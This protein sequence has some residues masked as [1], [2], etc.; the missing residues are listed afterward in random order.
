MTKP[1]NEIANI[2]FKKFG[3]LFQAIE[4]DALS[5]NT[6]LLDFLAT[7]GE[8]LE[9]LRRLIMLQSDRDNLKQDFT[10]S[11]LA[12]FLA[13][14]SVTGKETKI[15]D[16]CAGSGALT[17]QASKIN[18]NAEYTCIEYDKKMCFVLV[19]MFK[20]LKLTGY[21]LNYDVINRELFQTYYIKNGKVQSLL[22]YI[23]PNNFDLCISNP[24]FNVDNSSFLKFSLDYSKK[25]S[26]IFCN[27]VLDDK[28][29]DLKQFVDRLIICPDKMFEKTGIPTIVFSISKTPSET[30]GFY[31]LNNDYCT[32]SITELNRGG[33]DENDASH[34]NRL[35]QKERKIL[36]TEAVDFVKN[37]NSNTINFCS[38]VKR[39]KVELLRCRNYIEY[40]ED[41]LNSF[42]DIK[43]AVEELRN[44]IELQ[45]SIQVSLNTT[46]LKDVIPGGI[47]IGDF[48]KQKKQSEEINK[49][50]KELND[51][52][53]G[54]NLPKLGEHQTVVETKLN[55]IVFK[56]KR[57]PNNNL[58]AF[59]PMLIQIL[60]LFINY[61]YSLNCMENAAL[62]KVRD[63]LLPYLMNGTLK[64]VK[65]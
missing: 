14:I 45:E 57:F 59:A 23:L 51:C 46:F 25:A 22:T 61:I 28:K 11:S 15:L 29:F 55:E 53:P 17:I 36:K 6:E 39:N 63:T 13:G 34:Y 38:F 5:D 62:K 19:L 43:Q 12:Y 20:A 24:P 26:F 44:V 33:T 7:E 32:K 42:T 48:I 50:F 21:V 47:D 30:I 10:P 9:L 1:I 65:E 2:V 41:P 8:P 60:P 16:M 54:L 3:D 35:Y 58:F 64:V 37:A 40:S 31:D 18:P 52:N 27:S 56:F 4:K 49:N